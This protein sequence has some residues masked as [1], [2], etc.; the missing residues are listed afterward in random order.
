M[1][2]HVA[3]VDLLLGTA[4]VLTF[5]CSVGVAVMRDPYERM[6]FMGPPAIFSATLITVA[7]AI[8]QP[9]AQAWLKCALLSLVLMAINSVVTH[10][11][12]RAVH[13]RARSGRA[14]GTTRTSSDD[15]EPD[16]GSA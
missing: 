13:L 11:T 14:A 7:V 6:H 1:T 5:V 3:A 15:A 2:V 16:D 9:K 8:D 10:A 12:A 4:V